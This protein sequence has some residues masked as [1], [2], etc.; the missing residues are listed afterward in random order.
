MRKLTV[1]VFSAL[2]LLALTSFG[3]V[4]SDQP[5]PTDPNVRIGKLP[6]GMAYY[7]RKNA[8]PEHKVELRLAVNAG[9]I[10][11]REDQQGLAHF[12]EHMNFNGTAHFKKNELVSYLQSIGVRFGADINA[13]TSFDETVYQL[14]IPTENPELINKGLLVLEDWATGATL[15]IEEINK[16]RGVVLEE[17]RLGR[18]GEQR[19][20]DRY[21]PKLLRDSQYAQRLPIGKKDIL[22]K[23]D[24][25]SILDFYETWYRPDLMAIVVVGDLDVNAIEIK[26]RSE[27][28]QIK[29][30]RPFVKRETFPIPDTKGTIVAVETDKEAQITTSQIIFKKAPETVNTL[31]EL[32]QHLVREMHD[33]MLTARL[34]EIRQSPNPPFVFAAGGFGPLFREKSEFGLFGASGPENVGST[35]STLLT[36]VRRA[37]LFGF[38]SAELERMKDRYLTDYE[39][40]FKE[41][42]KS[43]STGFA[44]E[45][46]ANFLTHEPVPGIEFEYQ[47]AKSVLPTI[48]LGE[49]NEVAKTTTTDDNR[50][51][52]VT[53]SA[54]EGVKYPTEAELLALLRTAESAQLK[55]YTETVATEP[56]VKELPSGAAITDQKANTDLGLTYWTLSN[57]V[58]VI[59][60]P[61]DFKE[62]QILLQGTAPGG[63]SLVGD[64]KAVSANSLSQF[65]GELG[66]KNLSKNE[67]DKMLAG[68][69][70]DVGVGLS[71]TSEIVFGET[72]PKDLETMLQLVYLKFTSVNFNKPE[73]DSF[74]SKQK[75]FLPNLLNNPSSY[76]GNEVIKI[77]SQNNPRVFG[78][79]TVE[80]LDKVR[81]EDLQTVYKDRFADASGF[82]FVFA[83]NF[84]NDKIKPLILKYLGNLPSSKRNET[85][86]DLGIRPPTGKVDKTVNKGVDQKSQVRITFTGPSPF[87][88]D[89]S[90]DLS[91]LG[92]LLTIKLIEILREEKGG[93]YGVGA[94]GG[95]GRIPYER[96][97]F[98][99]AFPCGPENVNSLIEAAMAE[100]AKL[101]NGQ[102]EDKDIAK[103]KE[104][105]LVK[106][107]EDSKTNN[108][109][110]NVVSSNVTQGTRL[111]TEAQAETRINA[112]S[113]DALQNAAKKYLNPDNKI[114]IVLMPEAI[115]K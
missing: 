102:I 59:L 17:L 7:I 46:V 75:M 38:T 88:Q 111:F 11:E 81:F 48:T 103:V 2:L 76:F 74:I 112:I 94:S 71:D 51:I 55:P 108:Y 114:Q 3:Q 18:G 54:K 93:V 25:K 73:F 62:D 28:A 92:E 33:G 21:F 42:D 113:K 104:A 64:D 47:Y 9:S 98:T 26:I 14:S 89:E 106:L 56:L 53:G 66:V 20:R 96:Y 77:M 41:K 1:P 65:V 6:N 43:E 84:D 13:Y 44:D 37:Q 8:K 34:E 109:W 63:L 86:K 35:V 99:I 29:A 22:E 45:Y 49:V 16:E 4:R 23:F 91:A 79:P 5:I 72:T 52:I 105:R 39:N 97:T 36:E 19:M 82:T 68:K 69:K 95:L 78:L 40:R 30:K 80:Q 83:G 15:D 110:I 60:K 50:A 115:T 100:V 85:W 27:F 10:L 67:L 90:R 70:A 31:P 61:T 101:R 87:S 24:R 57:G 107:R 32:R 12:M 58:K